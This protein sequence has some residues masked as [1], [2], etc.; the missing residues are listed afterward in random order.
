VGFF[1][2]SESNYLTSTESTNTAVVSTAIVE[3]AQTSVESHDLTSVVVPLPQEA[4][5]TIANNATIFLIIVFFLFVY[6]NL[7]I[8]L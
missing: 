3:S 6:K 7:N 4:N 8:F 1:I 2:T 5:T